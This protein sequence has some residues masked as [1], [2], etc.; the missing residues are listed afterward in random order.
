MWVIFN[1]VFRN[2]FWTTVLWPRVAPR[3]AVVYHYSRQT[4]Q[5]T[6]NPSPPTYN[7]HCEHFMASVRMSILETFPM[8]YKRYP[9]QICDFFNKLTIMVFWLHF[10]QHCHSNIFK[11]PYVWLYNAIV[12]M[13][14][15]LYEPLLCFPY[16][17]SSGRVTLSSISH[18]RF[19]HDDVIKWKH[20]PRYWPF[21]RGIH[22]SPVNSPHKGQWRGA[23]MFSLICVWINGWVNNRE[24]GN[25]RRYRAHY[26]V[27]VMISSRYR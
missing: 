22:R 17:A 7:R 21:V 19:W 24:A 5:W 27:I 18:C 23:L 4:C 12:C 15:Y 26:D 16:S 25:L 13:Y 9:A 3:D 2:I 20:F 10:E 11:M 6:M 1:V 8:W 14:V